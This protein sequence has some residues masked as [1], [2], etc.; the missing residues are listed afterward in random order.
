MHDVSSR[1]AARDAACADAIVLCGPEAPPPGVVVRARLDREEPAAFVVA[2]DIGWRHAAALG[3]RVDVVVGDLDS[4]TDDEVRA[5]TAAGA[6][7]DRHPV[8]KDATDLELAMDAALE[9][10]ARTIV[11]IDGGPGARVDHFLAN[12]LVLAH[13][14]YAAAVVHG[15]LSHSWVTVVHP[16]R[17]ATI[18]GRTGATVSLLPVGG[19]AE[20]VT[21][22]GLRWPLTGGRLD[23]H[24][25]RGVS[26]ELTDVAASVSITAGTLL[27][28][29]PLEA[30]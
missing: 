17:R 18:T 3:L 7:I 28:V 21:T 9:H 13:P 4:L 1:D 22:S 14:R 16:E 8:D 6:R 10:G 29:Q 30:A 19:H 15:A 27:V 12:A 24:S 23:A 2:A 25:T 11:V 5:A 20:G 26:N